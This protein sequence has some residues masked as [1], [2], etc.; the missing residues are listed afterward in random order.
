MLWLC[1]EGRAVA[2]GIDSHDYWWMAVSWRLK[3][4]AKTT[5]FSRWLTVTSFFGEFSLPELKALTKSINPRC[6]AATFKVL[7]R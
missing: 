3:M 7:I 1:V 4:A 6:V 2:M 5:I